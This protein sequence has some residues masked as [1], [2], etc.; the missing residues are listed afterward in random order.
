M[1]CFI[2]GKVGE[3][4]LLLL[5]GL[6]YDTNMSWFKLFKNYVALAPLVSKADIIVLRQFEVNRRQIHSAIKFSIEVALFQSF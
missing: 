4:P 6:L 2:F 1:S 5:L 3:N